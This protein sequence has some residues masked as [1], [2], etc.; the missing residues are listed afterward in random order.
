MA[1]FAFQESNAQSLSNPSARSGRENSPY[2]MFGIGMLSPNPTS[3]LRGMGG[4]GTAYSDPFTFNVDNPASYSFL[5]YSTLEFSADMRSRTI[6]FEGKP[7]SNSF[8]GSINNLQMGIPLKGIGGLSFGIHQVSNIYY[9]MSDTINILT[10]RTIRQYAG[11]GG[12]QKAY[13]GFALSKYNISLGANLGYTFGQKSSGYNL[14][15]FN[16]SNIRDVDELIS[17]K[18]NGLTWNFGAMYKLPLSKDRFFSIGASYQ[19]ESDLKGNK[20]GYTLAK[21]YKQDNNGIQNIISVDTL[22]QFKDSKGTMTLPSTFGIGLHY[23]KHEVID[24]IADFRY[25]DWSNF[26]NYG[27]RD[28]VAENAFRGSVGFSYTPDFAALYKSGGSYLSAVTYRAGFYY[29]KDYVTLRNTSIVDLG[30]TIGFGLPVRRAMSNNQFAKI[31][32]AFTFGNRGTFTNGLAREFY[33]NFTFGASL[34]DIW[35]VKPTYD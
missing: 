29:N 23:G 3:A 6:T 11:N 22:S 2:S 32:T 14:A 19:L 21:T 28:S 13:F 27:I 35:F 8:T 5:R 24:I 12:L 25:Y 30:G 34:N 18:Y 10:D 26:S 1:V 17:T 7:S 20:I 33:F 15:N 16:N 9:N 31:N 4:G